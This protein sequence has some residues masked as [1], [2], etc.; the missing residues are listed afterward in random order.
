VSCAK[1]EPFAAIGKATV[2]RKRVRR[3]VVDGQTYGW[4]VWMAD[5]NFVS[6]RLWRDGDRVPIADVR[7]PFDDPWLLFPE[8]AHV[9]SRMP[10]RFPDRFALDPVR[11]YQ[12][13]ELIRA[14]VGHGGPRREF[15]LVNGEL[16]PVG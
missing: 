16:R 12:V 3:I 4:R 10:D 6:L 9:Y 1:I 14:C 2:V 8:M 15:E 5:E 13:A 11:P 7:L